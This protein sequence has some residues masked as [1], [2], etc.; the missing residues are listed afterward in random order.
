MIK[1]R[2]NFHLVAVLF[3][4]PAILLYTVLL[5]NPV[6]QSVRM[7]FFSWNGI[8]QSPLVFAGL[9]NYKELLQSGE[10]WRALANVGKFLAVGFLLQMPV[11]FILSLI[12]TSNIKAVRFFKTIFFVPVI[13]PITAISIMWTF[14][15]WPTGGSLNSIMQLLG[16][17]A[18]IQDWLG[19]PNIVSITIPLINLWIAV[20]LNMIIFSAGMV[21]IPEE[22]YEAAE[23]DGATGVKKVWNITLPLMKES[24]K[25]YSVLCVTGCLKVFDIVY[26]MTSGGP[27]GASDVPA[28]LLYY[29]AF[30]YQK[31]GFASSIGTV[32]LILGLAVSIL[33]NK[34]VNNDE[35]N[36]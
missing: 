11:S 23:I 4:L 8:A 2:W 21:S 1:R 36:N 16:M 35:L 20:G 7:S 29:S 18:L 26:V 27:N 12:I 3:V 31:Y 6:I 34:F 17:Q 14:I 22:L 32:I 25:I 30:K 24:I 5:I 15:L 10:F 9:D 19:D 28:T 33:I 13:L